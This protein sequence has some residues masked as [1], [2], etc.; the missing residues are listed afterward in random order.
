MDQV[1]DNYLIAKEKITKTIIYLVL[2]AILGSA[3]AQLNMIIDS[4]YLSRIADPDIAVASV[5]ATGIAFP[6][7]L[8][9]ISFSN[10]FG[11]G[12]SIYGAQSLG[13]NKKEKAR[14]IFTG[15]LRSAFILNIVFI[16]ILLIF[17][18]PILYG[19]G[20]T[21]ASINL[22][23]NYAFWCVLGS[24]TSILTFIIV[25]F[26]RS[27]GK[28]LLVFKAIIVQ[29]IANFVLN[30]IFIFPLGMGTAGA[31]IATVLSQGIQMVLTGAYMFTNKSQFQY[32]FGKIDFNFKEFKKVFAYGFPSTIGFIYITLT[33]LIL[34][35]ETSFFADD[36]IN[37]ALGILVKF[38]TMF[39][40]MT[41]A[42]VSGIQPVFSFSYGAKDRARFDEA[43][44]T[45][46]KY[47][48]IVSSIIGIALIIDPALPTYIFS[49]PSKADQYVIF[50]TTF[51]GMMLLT[52]PLSFLIQ[53]LFQSINKADTSLKIVSIRQVACFIVI[54]PIFLYFFNVKGLIS[55]YQVSVVV[56]SIIS[57]ILYKS[58]L[59]TTIENEFK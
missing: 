3:I 59:K 51:L 14:D 2:P 30:Y 8:M 5:A 21:D 53:I 24:P 27:E 28:A 50:G 15:T 16:I 49:L 34:T 22:S 38:F 6:I 47:L 35:F 52:M 19:L 54:N 17:L 58:K 9:V 57:I 23:Y 31:S 10:L 29:T 33:A 44:K 1:E 7:L 48:L 45:F 43:S 46:G 42:A 25:M 39:T 12:G 32:R 55:S 41:Q 56:G 4:L 26:A 36:N 37:A 11:I 13:A 20:A 40:M 18:R